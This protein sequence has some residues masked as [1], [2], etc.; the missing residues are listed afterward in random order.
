MPA[1]IQFVLLKL[2]GSLVSGSVNR[3]FTVPDSF[4]Q[5]KNEFGVHVLVPGV[6]PVVE[7]V[8]HV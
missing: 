5:A 3:Q 2:K 8:A 4:P 1:I 7:Y 6:D